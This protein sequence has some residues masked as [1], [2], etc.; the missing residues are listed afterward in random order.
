VIESSYFPYAFAL[1]LAI[2]FLVLLRQYI[3]TMIRLKNQQIK[4]LSVKAGGEGKI[5]AYERMT[6]FLERIKP[7]NLSSKFDKNLQPHEFVFL[8]EKNIQEEFDYNS[9]Q[10]LY[11]TKNAWQNIVAS[12]NTIVQMMH[13]TYENLNQNAKLE[14]FKTVFLMN[15]LN[16]E[17]FI[18]HTIE[19]LRK[20]FLLVT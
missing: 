3:Y 17:D 10:Q 1:L 8:T 7:A 5:L 16:G 12:K 6:L 4:M 18:A 11:L 19:D 15:Y 2:P 13:Q 9:S 14:D 20:D